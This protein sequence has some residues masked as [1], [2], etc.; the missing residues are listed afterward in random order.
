MF[1]PLAEVVG[2]LQPRATESKLVSGAGAWT[3]HRSDDGHPVYS[4]VL[5]GSCRL[6]IGDNAPITLEP[7]DFVLVPALYDVR[8]SSIAP[9]RSDARQAPVQTVGG[10][11]RL[12]SA[13]PPDF[14][15]LV[16][17][18]TFG[19]SDAGL[20]LSLLP[21]FVH[22]RGKG[23]LTTLV[24]LVDDE[25]RS[26]LPGRELV[27]A[28][29]LEVL[30]IEALR[31]TGGSAAPPGLLRGLGDR[32]LAAALR[33]MHA[34]PGQAWTMGRLAAEAGLSRSAFFEHFKREMGVAPMLYLLRW[35]MALAKH[36]LLRETK[37]LGAVAEQIG[38]GSASAFSIAFSR[39]CGM[40]PM[41]Y[42]RSRQS[43]STDPAVPA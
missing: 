36:L 43:E 24:Q 1:D 29:L 3:A 11:V 15:M 34:S 17:H 39:H 21:Q 22:I 10:T 31:S 38:Y 41:Q 7:G 18:F 4:A 6:T 33:L 5:A 8:T 35:R 42:V 9:A 26:D 40:S 37:G 19:S 16:G 12:G 27:L 13:D 25:A 20:L 28:R 2:L 14:L 32:R 30:L 23:R